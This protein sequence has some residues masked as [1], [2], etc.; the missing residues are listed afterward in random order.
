MNHSPTIRPATE[1]DALNIAAI[2]VAS[3]QKIYEKKMPA[4]V[5][6]NLSVEKRA[7]QWRAII[8]KNIPV[9][10]LEL[11]NDMLGFSCL[12]PARD[13]DLNPTQCGEI[14]AIYLNP[15]VWRQG[16][17]EKLCLASFNKLIEM[18]FSEVVVWVLAENM[19]ARKFYEA[20]GFIHTGNTKVETANAAALGVVCDDKTIEHLSITLHE[21]RYSKSNLKHLFSTTLAE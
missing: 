7:Q 14:S 20:M 16:F 1:N 13:T 3:W 4:A 12:C 21:V 9:L 6:A 5:L 8:N 19:Q 10:V 2:H 15:N 11:N 18:N 17:G